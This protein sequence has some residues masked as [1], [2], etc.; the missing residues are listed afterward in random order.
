M[1]FKHQN[2]KTQNEINLNKFFM[3]ILLSFSSYYFS[4]K[5]S[6][7]LLFIKLVLF[8]AFWFVYF[9]ISSYNWILVSL[10]TSL[11]LLQ[12][13]FL[14][15]SRLEDFFYVLDIENFFVSLSINQKRNNNL[16]ID[17]SWMIR[18]EDSFVHQKPIAVCTYVALSLTDQISIFLPINES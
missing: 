7:F 6:L 4:F 17:I 1:I 11:I 5:N 9:C 3:I 15:R 8:I 14:Y 18:N 16:I 10:W 13:S 2:Y 12:S